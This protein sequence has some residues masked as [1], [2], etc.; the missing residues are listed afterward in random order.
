MRACL[1]AHARPEMLRDANLD[2]CDLGVVC[3]KVRYQPSAK[4]FDLPHG[5]LRSEGIY[6]VPHRVSGKNLAVVAFR[7]CG[8]EVALELNV[9]RDVFDLVLR[10]GSGHA[11]QAHTRLSVVI[12]D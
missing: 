6:G 5:L 1:G 7:M 3:Q 11:Q 4:V 8:V 12:G 2:C 10:T 9:D